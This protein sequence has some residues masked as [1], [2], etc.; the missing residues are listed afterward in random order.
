[1]STDTG[2]PKGRARNILVKISRILGWT[3]FS[4]F[5]LLLAAVLIVR[6]PAIQNK[7]AQ[8]VINFLEEKIG[9]NVELERI[10]IDFPK[11]IVIEGLFLEDQHKDT[12]LYA[13]RIAVDAGMFGLLRNEI[14]LSQIE[15]ENSSAIITRTLPDSAFNF[16]YIINAFSG[17]DSTTTTADSTT[18]PWKF[19]LGTV[20]I[21]NVRFRYQDAISD[22][23]LAT[24]IGEFETDADEIDPMAMI[25]KLDGIRLIN[26]SVAV[27]MR[28]TPTTP[29]LD[30]VVGGS[31]ATDIIVGF[32]NAF[33]ENVKVK[34]S[35]TGTDQ[36]LNA[37]IGLLEVEADNIDLKQQLIELGKL[38]LSKSF[39][40]FHQRSSVTTTIAD[41]S[42]VVSPLII[43]PWAV[44]VDD[45]V[46]QQNA[47]E[48]ADFGFPANR[49]P[50]DP[51]RIW[52][53]NLNMQASGIQVDSTTAEVDLASLS[54][55]EKKGIHL[56]NLAGDIKVNSTSAAIEGL[57]LLYG[58][59]KL[60]LTGNVSYPSLAV[61]TSDLTKVSGDIA[62]SD[63]YLVVADLLTFQPHILDSLP[64]HVPATTRLALN[65]EAGGNM[66]EA[67]I[68][69][70]ELRTLDSTY[71]S[72][73]GTAKGLSDLNTA[74]L[75]ASLK[76]FHTS[77]S[78]IKF[79]LPDSLLPDSSGLPSYVVLDGTVKGTIQKP[80]VLAK[81]ATDL[82]TITANAD[83]S[84]IGIPTY[85][86]HVTA[87]DVQA[88]KLSGIPELGDVNFDLSVAG[89]GIDMETLDTKIDLLVKDLVYN[90]YHFADFKLN[91]TM[92]KYLF[93]GT[94]SLNDENLAFALDADLDY[95]GQVP[96]YKAKFDLK[97][98]NLRE[99]NLSERPLR[100]RLVVDV[101]LST[102]DFQVMN[103]RLDIRKVAVFNGEKLYAVD[104]ML[105]AS[106]DQ[107]GKSKMS[108]RSD[109]MNGDFEGT[110]NVFSIAEKLTQ[111]FEQYFSPNASAKSS[112]TPTSGEVQNFTFDLKI[113]NTDLITEVLIPELEPFTPGVI[114]GEFDSEAN[115]LNL[116]FRMPRL[117]YGATGVDS[118]VLL[119]NSDAEELSWL[120]KLD[121]LVADT[122]VIDQVNLTGVVSHDSIRT[123][124]NIL[125]SLDQ[126]KYAIGARIWRD[127]KMMRIRLDNSNL[128][129]NYSKWD[130]PADNYL[131]VGNGVVA[132]SNFSIIKQE[133]KITMIGDTR[134][135][136]AITVR[137]EEFELGNLTRVISGVV[138]A[139]GELNGDFKFTTASSGAF[140]SNLTIA[141]LTVLQKPLGDLS[142]GLE[143][144]EN[145]YNIALKLRGNQTDLET[146]G[147][148]GRNKGN[149]ELNLV[150]NITQLNMEAV[151][152]FSM[153]Q[154]T[155]A[156]GIVTGKMQVTG[157]PTHPNIAGDLT[158]RDVSLVSTFLNSKYSLNNETIAINNDIVTFTNFTIA[159]DQKNTA[160]L[161]GAVDISNYAEPKF[162]LTLTTRNF[163][164]LNTEEGDNE[165][166]YGLVKI[167]ATARVKG[168]AQQPTA[169]LKLSFSDDTNFTYVVP[170]SER[171]VLEAEGIVKFVDRDSQG[172]PFLESLDASDTIRSGFSGI[173]VSAVIDLSDQETLNVVI[174]PTTGDKLVVQGNASL[175][176]DMTSSGNMNLSGRYEISKGTYN[177][178]FYNLVK[179]K[180][181]IVKGSS[182]TWSGDPLNAAMDIRASN[183]V[184][185]SPIDLV[186]SQASSSESAN[187][188]N[189]RLPF[190]VYLNIKDQLLAPQISFQ[191][192]MPADKRNA[193]GGVYYSKIQD[194]NSRESDLNKQVFALLILK[195]F[196]A[197]NPF[198]SSSGGGVSNTARTSVSRVLSEQLNRLSENVKGVQLSF[199]IK[200]YEQ[201]GVQGTVWYDQGPTRCI[202][203]SLLNDRLIVKL[204][205]N[206]DIEGEEAGSIM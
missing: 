112:T 132:A 120:F 63:S 104:S 54:F 127:A 68:R 21:R 105:F 15:L 3:L 174:D 194:I 142:L 118:L 170:T 146:T 40:S 205:G 42:L 189:Q 195:R 87:R 119:V 94:A 93:D 47:I 114:R 113:K 164:V 144:A 200:S 197:D 37:T 141:G 56:G 49:E 136:P 71:L 154:I 130:V 50:F 187:N 64:L 161:K 96:V 27:A 108:I 25:F 122:I 33:I 192:D 26:S 73:S 138:P 60:S 34:Y 167:N 137:F 39:V 81:L 76:T 2:V 152:A 55:T 48:Y 52:I 193:N 116:T 1:M 79:I 31:Q 181:D 70:L 160:Q 151:Q 14:N 171:A 67:S 185:T 125:D 13:E 38:E 28:S 190:L 77:A 155:N 35:D 162:D 9:T 36:E 86:A 5:V 102:S 117:K 166:F 82:G 89:K 44:R 83:L 12:L 129:L 32:K 163:Q 172:D 61:L 150:A 11:K 85:D 19:S 101:D 78:D 57:E 62:M 16:D 103:G 182:I 69:K 157:K 65:L 58:S 107:Q 121:R 196:V 198:E 80:V 74:T 92:V 24:R 177:L 133:Q 131:V 203:K 202:Q 145:Q 20:Q 176:F 95:N 188:F 158:F 199:D 17:A 43:S 135:D 168:S 10:T 173:E 178:S 111:H 153:G 99:L 110:F 139:S 22:I 169:S 29:E 148:Y 41:S 23:S 4:I 106:L 123:T 84:F 53:M 201:A 140:S 206:V 115:K 128:F 191:L 184:E 143:H 147:T 7:I 97:N 75:D 179:R 88:G 59:S 72:L 30:P 134:E 109:I 18:T 66:S 46:L 51:N 175:T 186:S 6:V 8:K 90:D 91:G 180:F 204:S 98:L 149:E 124:F 45:I 156:S 126:K 159:D 100:A 183:L 165:L